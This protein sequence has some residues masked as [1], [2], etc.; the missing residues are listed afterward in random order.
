MSWC[1]RYENL[2]CPTHRGETRLGQKGFIPAEQEARFPLAGGAVTV[3]MLEV[4]S[5][6]HDDGVMRWLSLVVQPKSAEH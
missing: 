3:K 1:K 6:A 4:D 5:A 2:V